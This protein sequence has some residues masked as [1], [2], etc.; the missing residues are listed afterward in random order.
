MDNGFWNVAV[1]SSSSQPNATAQTR[2]YA[3]FQI[4]TN[5]RNDL[6]LATNLSNPS[7]NAQWD[8]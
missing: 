5:Q 4:V 3:S 8:I 1:V 7:I 6:T 2:D